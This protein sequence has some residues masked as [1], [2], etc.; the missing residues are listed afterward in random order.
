VASI[1]LVTSVVAACLA[2]GSL[3]HSLLSTTKLSQQFV[4]AVEAS[5]ESLAFLQRQLTSLDRVALQNRRALD[6]LT[7][8]KG[9][10]CLFL[11]EECCFYAN[12]SGIIVETGI[13]QLHKLKLEL[14][15]KEFSVDADNWWKSSMYT[16]LMPLLGPLISILLVVTLGPF[17]FNRIT[18]FI[19]QQIDFLVSRPLQI[20][21]HRLNLAD[22]GLAEPEVDNSPSEAA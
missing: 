22:R 14:Q 18:G 9:G 19:K 12:K 2:G 1:S 5:I 20:Y 16:L 13:Q 11:Q 6:L 17:I 15:R 8:E 10:T 4:L 3:T 21:Y 7:A